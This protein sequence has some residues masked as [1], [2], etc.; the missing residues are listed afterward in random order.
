MGA[1]SVRTILTWPAQAYQR[2]QP[3]WERLVP[4]AGLA[5]LLWVV[6]GA[7]QAYPAEWRWFLAVA[8]LLVGLR[9]PTWAYALFVVALAYPLYRVSLYLAALALACLILSARWVVRNLSL[10][11]LVL[12]TP[13]LLPW[14]LEGLTP[15]LAGL[16]WGE[17][18]GALAGGLAALGLK[19]LA[20]MA[21]QPLDLARLSGWTPS[22]AVLVERYSPLNSWRTLTTLVNP[23]ADT[24]R[25]LLFHLLQ[26]LAWGGVGYLVGWL[27]RRAWSERWRRWA[28]LTAT[29]AGAA[30]LAASYVLLSQTV[31]AQ[32]APE[33]LLLDYA[34]W[35][36]LV[37]LT[38]AACRF[39]YLSLRRPW[40]R[41]RPA[42]ANL[43]ERP[44]QPKSDP[45][46]PWPRPPRRPVSDDEGDVIMLELD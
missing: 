14:H 9:S 22:A 45:P 37:G 30:G 41:P 15:L 40:H 35:S 1:V 33:S 13:A 42:S 31:S 19:L 17:A 5:L 2:F 24:S 16:W 34:F 25:T 7:T 11:V 26:I 46:K 39:G 44:R 18:T 12:L 38:A 36:L 4:A 6:S 28:P 32:A 8:L 23:F 10:F 29:L 20:G 43:P 27:A 3:F 21:A